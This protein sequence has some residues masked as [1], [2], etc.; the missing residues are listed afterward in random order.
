MTNQTDVEVNHKIKPY[1]N[2][3]A[4]RLWTSHATVMVG[5]GFSKNATPVVGGK[6]QFPTWNELCEVFF[7]KVNG[8]KPSG[9]TKFLNPLKLAEEIEV[10]FG[11]ETLNTLL[12]DKIP[13]DSH[14]PTELFTKLLELEWRDVFTTNFDT[15]LERAK[16]DITERNYQVVVKKEEFNNSK[17]P[18]IIKLHGI[19][20]TGDFRPR[21]FAQFHGCWNFIVRVGDQMNSVAE[22]ALDLFPQRTILTATAGLVFAPVGIGVI[23]SIFA[24]E[25]SAG[26]MRRQ[27]FVI[28]AQTATEIR[29]FCH[30]LMAQ[31]D[32]H[33]RDPAG[34]G[35]QLEQLFEKT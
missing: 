24:S 1:L 29:H 14:R 19:S 2:E 13:D 4:E 7:E 34:V 21:G 28:V 16:G 32:D 33:L 17:A 18:R 22:P 3:I 20:Q 27:H 11:R 26:R 35:L 8:Q 31:P 10:L 5:A 15:L 9:Q 30:Q 6:N 12:K 23:G 25:A